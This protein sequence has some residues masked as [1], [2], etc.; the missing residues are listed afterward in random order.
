MGE[1][2][3]KPDGIELVISHLK[4]ERRIN[5][6]YFKDFAGANESAAGGIDV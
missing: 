4:S 5:Y 2:F 3:P 6:H 1:R